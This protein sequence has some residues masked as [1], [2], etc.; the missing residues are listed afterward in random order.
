[1]PRKIQKYNGMVHQQFIDLKN[2]KVQAM[3]SVVR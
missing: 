1:M 2:P 3:K